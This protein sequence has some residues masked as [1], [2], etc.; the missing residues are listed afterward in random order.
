M[1]GILIV[2]YK[3]LSNDFNFLLETFNYSQD[4]TF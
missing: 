4:L 1:N 2:S 3:E